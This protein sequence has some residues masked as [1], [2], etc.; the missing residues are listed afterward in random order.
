V[1]KRGRVQKRKEWEESVTEA[2]SAEPQPEGRIQ[3]TASVSAQPDGKKTNKCGVIGNGAR[4]VKG[5][6]DRKRGCTRNDVTFLE[7]AHRLENGERNK[8]TGKGRKDF[9]PVKRGR[10][11]WVTKKAPQ[12]EVK[13]L[14]TREK[15]KRQRGK[16]LNSARTGAANQEINQKKDCLKATGPIGIKRV[17]KKSG[18][19]TTVGPEPV[20]VP[21]ERDD[22][23]RDKGG[24]TKEKKKRL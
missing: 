19:K 2:M 21:K 24:T 10:M 14:N 23:Q 18:K 5:R 6:N 7:K 12:T 11:G 22:F 13:K 1:R 9:R 15:G 16:E 17:G 8:T 3:L 20:P 4:G